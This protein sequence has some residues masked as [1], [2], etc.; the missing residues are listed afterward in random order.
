MYNIFCC[1]SFGIRQVTSVLEHVFEKMDRI[2]VFS[3]DIFGFKLEIGNTIYV[4]WIIMAALILIAAIITRGLSVEKPG[5]L[6]I[7]AEM[8][9][10]FVNNLCKGAIHHHWR[11]FVPFVGTM[12]LFISSMNI[13]TIFNF[14][15]GVH[16]YPPTKDINIAG[17]LA[18]C[19]LV[20]TIYASFRYLGVKGWAKSLVS[21][22]PVMLPFKLLEYVTKPLSLCLRLF[23]NI[24]AAFLIMELL[25]SFFPFVG[26]PFSAYFDLFD[27]ILQAYIFVY[28]T[29]I[30][31]GEA[32]EEPE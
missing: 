28:L 7:I 1:S 26:A 11:P 17:A 4:S 5:K 25:M 15:P 10:G 16:L 8:L 23:G 18:V 2:V 12:L 24:F 14:F 32:V 31:I 6:Q 27:G 29:T 9:V 21:P 30:Y 22:M 20:V 19:S 3:L 13:I